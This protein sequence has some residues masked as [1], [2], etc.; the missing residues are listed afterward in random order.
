MDVKNSKNLN[1]DKIEYIKLWQNLTTQI[2]TNL[3]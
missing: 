3:K 1:C 2:V